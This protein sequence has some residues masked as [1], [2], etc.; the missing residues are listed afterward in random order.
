MRFIDVPGRLS[1]SIR[2][3]QYPGRPEN[4]TEKSGIDAVGLVSNVTVDGVTYGK[5]RQHGE[6]CS[7]INIASVLRE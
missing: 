5:R 3:N 2:S 6:H 1:D 7:S 4:S